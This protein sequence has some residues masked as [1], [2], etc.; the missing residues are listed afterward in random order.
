MSPQLAPPRSTNL[1]EALLHVGGE[2][3]QDAQLR[4]QGPRHSTHREGEVLGAGG[5]V[6]H[7][8]GAEEMETE[9]RGRPVPMPSPERPQ[10]PEPR[11]TQQDTALQSSMAWTQ[12]TPSQHL[13]LVGR[14]GHVRAVVEKHSHT[15]A[16][17]LIPKAKLVGVVDPF[18]N[19]YQ[20]L[21]LCQ[22][23]RVLFGC[24]GRESNEDLFLASQPKDSHHC[25]R[26]PDS[27]L[28]WG[29][30]GQAVSQGTECGLH[31]CGHSE[32]FLKP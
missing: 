29:H 4:L 32:T 15:A 7:S 3:P 11:S 31:H 12:G 30:E 17:Q 16:G 20:G 27:S 25:S 13:L 26:V 9:V 14:Q 10:A 22:G 28:T 18:A 8:P 5:V 21:R 23:S 6:V 24:H 2:I 19:P 1:H